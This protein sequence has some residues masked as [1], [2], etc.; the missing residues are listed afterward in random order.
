D[1]GGLLPDELLPPRGLFRRSLSR[2]FSR[3]GPDR[4]F[5]EARIR[6]EDF[7]LRSMDGSD[8]SR[9]FRFDFRA[10]DSSDPDS[11]YEDAFFPRGLH[12]G[13][14][15]RWFLTLGPFRLP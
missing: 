4:G 10:A 15:C 5:F 8:S 12:E 9:R 13:H 11:L 14:R 3:L 7:T 6:T 2:V 1:P